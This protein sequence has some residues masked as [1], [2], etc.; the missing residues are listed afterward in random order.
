MSHLPLSLWV[1]FIILRVELTRLYVYEYY[2]LW[3]DLTWL[4]VIFILLYV[5]VMYNFVLWMSIL[6]YVF[7][8]AQLC[9]NDFQYYYIFLSCT[10]LYKWLSKLFLWVFVMHIFV[11]MTIHII[12]VWIFFMNIFVRTTIHI[13]M[14]FRHAHLCT[15]EYYVP[16]FFPMRFC[17]TGILSS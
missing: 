17:K 14:G 11:R 2:M 6:V 10:S 4:F 16:N 3:V 7:C 12:L 8:H 1:N 15:N 9:T 5:F 13:L